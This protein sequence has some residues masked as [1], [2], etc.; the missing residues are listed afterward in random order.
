[1]DRASRKDADRLATAHLRVQIARPDGRIRA[2][3]HVRVTGRAGTT[4][5]VT[6]ARLSRS[7][8]T[9]DQNAEGLH[10]GCQ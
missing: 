4:G 2:K 6:G 10:G 5:F 9:R 3:C 1:M 8:F 7:S